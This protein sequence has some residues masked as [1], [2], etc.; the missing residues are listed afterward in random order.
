MKKF[1]FTL[2]SLLSTKISMEKQLKGDISI[3]EAR[4]NG[5]RQELS[6]MEEHLVEARKQH[7]QRVSE[8][9]SPQELVLENVGFRALFDRIAQQHEKIEVA[10]QE[11]ARIQQQLFTVMMDRKMLEKLREK[12]KREYMEDLKKEEAA[13]M[14]D[15]LS[16]RLGGRDTAEAKTGG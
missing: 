16:S 13:M 8:G 1:R 7:N 6:A 15:F 5:F 14:D 12:Q 3:V 2:Q 4:I 11:K 9:I 10:T